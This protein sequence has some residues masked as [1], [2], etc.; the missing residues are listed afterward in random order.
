[1]PS[2]EREKA[3]FIQVYCNIKFFIDYKR[4]YKFK[5]GRYMKNKKIF[6]S[7]MATFP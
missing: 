1:M 5:Y 7:F 4:N 6:N 3:L 2:R